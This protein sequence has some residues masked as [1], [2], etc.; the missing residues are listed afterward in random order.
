MF[1]RLV[2]LDRTLISLE[3]ASVTQK[4]QQPPAALLKRTNQPRHVQ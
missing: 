2:I 3:A 4:A 1:R